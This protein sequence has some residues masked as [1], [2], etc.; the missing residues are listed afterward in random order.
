AGEYLDRYYPKSVRRT[1][2]ELNLS[3]KDLEG[4][5]DLTDFTNLRKLDFSHNPKL[6]AVWLSEDS[7]KTI[8]EYNISASGA[9][10]K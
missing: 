5:L 10:G 1:A 6:D 2:W 3:N 4:V 8:E 7:L 9:K